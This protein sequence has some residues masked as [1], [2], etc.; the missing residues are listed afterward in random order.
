[1]DALNDVFLF[2]AVCSLPCYQICLLSLLLSFTI[3][4]SY[5]VFL[6]RRSKA[7]CAQGSFVVCT[8]SELHRRLQL[9]ILRFF[10]YW[11][12][13]SWIKFNNCPTRCD[14]FSLLHFCRQLYMFQVLP[15]IIRSWYS[16]NYSFWYWPDLL[17]S[18]LVAE[19][20]LIHIQL[21]NESIW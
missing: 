19:L 13:A 4:N 3:R 10:I 15:P 17:P 5:C 2:G 20:E 12:C 7:H 14:L 9:N 18:A 11:V 16:C 1:M 6:T 21:N 8:W